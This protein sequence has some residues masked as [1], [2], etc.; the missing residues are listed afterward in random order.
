M[1]TTQSNQHHTEA[2]L[3]ELVPRTAKRP[4]RPRSGRC[5]GYSQA[6]MEIPSPLPAAEST[7]AGNPPAFHA[8]TVQIAL[9]RRA[10]P[11]YETYQQ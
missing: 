3:P 8:L 11:S 6:Q 2:S 7:T 4:R 10:E 5:A 9:T 1:D